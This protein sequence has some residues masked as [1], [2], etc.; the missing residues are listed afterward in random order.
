MSD[1]SLVNKISY[2]KHLKVFSSLNFFQ[3]LKIA[4]KSIIS[5]YKK[6][7]IIC[8]EGDPAD[9]FY[10]II[11][12]RL[13]S[14]TLN[15]FDAKE[16]IDFIHR[17]MYFGVVSVLTDET[18]SLNYQAINNSLILQ[19]PKYDFKEALKSF[20]KL[21]I[22]L[23]LTLSQQVRKKVKG[24]GADFESNIISV[25][26]PVKGTGSTSY[27]FNL[28][29]SLKKE[30]NKKV[31]FVSIYS[32][33][34]TVLDNSQPTYD[35]S[36]KWKKPGLRLNEIVEDYEKMSE[37]IVRDELDM[38]MLNIAFE[39]KDVSPDFLRREIDSLIST[40]VGDYHYVIVDLPNDMDDVVLETLIQSDLIHLIMSD[41]KKDLEQIVPVLNKLRQHLKNN[42]RQEK[43]RVL[44]KSVRNQFYL[45]FEEINKVIGYDV[46]KMLP[47][48]G[49]SDLI[50]KIDTENI[51][52][53]KNSPKSDYSREVTRISREIGKVLVGLVL[54]GG[55]ALGIAHIG[56]LKV[57]EENDIPIDVVVGSSMGALIAALWSTGK[58]ADEIEKI[59]VEFKDKKNMLKLFDPVMPISG[60]IGGR[61]IKKW[62]KKYLG[63]KTFYSAKIPLKVIAYDLTRREDIIYES[64]SILDA[65]RESISIP[66]VIEPIRKQG[67]LVIDGGVVNPLPVDVLVKRGVKKIIAVNV[68]Q[69]PEDVA[70]GVDILK[71]SREEK[72]NVSFKESPLGYIK[73]KVAKP[74]DNLFAPSISDIIVKTL[75]ATEYFI[76]EKSAKQANVLIHPDLIGIEWYELN[77]VDEIVKSGED[78][79]RDL[80][81]NI[82]RLI[83]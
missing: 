49:D 5:E 26:S 2:I 71:H 44:I 83:S 57:L 70:E 21:A 53:L 33:E 10:C 63:D 12:G 19:I 69:S 4:L 72:K 40:L 51:A 39:Q 56:V 46:Y 48:I 58:S 7:D 78:A 16:D 8:N 32:K 14:Y 20:P 75:Q 60:F 54:G 41:R 42:F 1:I 37:G 17:G 52:C 25:Y 22:E 65:V 62:L 30:T 67:K 29:L 15:E 43:V 24:R 6:G 28:A 66:G 35:I 64:G 73:A 47:N 36:P 50:G 79:T 59:A 31:I 18:H 45:S 80:L 34:S 77:R 13:R 38:D 74:F 3:I 9:F 61:A 68:L 76:A 27:A 11:S 81:P 23:S 55:A 82:K